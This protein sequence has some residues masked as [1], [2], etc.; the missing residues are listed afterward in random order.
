MYIVDFFYFTLHLISWFNHILWQM[1]DKTRQYY[2]LT[3]YIHFTNT[4]CC[5]VDSL[6]SMMQKPLV[7]K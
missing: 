2:N 4:G 5:H 7:I 3:N 6:Y 1:V